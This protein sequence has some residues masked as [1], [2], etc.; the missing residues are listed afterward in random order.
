MIGCNRHVMHAVDAV[1]DTGAGPNLVHEAMLP[2]DW[3]RYT[4]T[5]LDF[6][7]IRDANN[8]SIRVEGAITLH[9]DIGGQ[10]L[11][12]HFLVCRELAV[13]VILGCSFIQRFVQAILPQDNKV[14]LRYGG[15]VAI[16]S[17]RTPDICVTHPSNKERSHP[18]PW[19]KKGSSRLNHV[20]VVTPIVIPP[21][22]EATIQVRC[23]RGGIRTILPSEDLMRK[24]KVSLTNGVVDALA[25]ACFLMKMANFSKR[26]VRLLKGTRVGTLASGPKFVVCPTLSKGSTSQDGTS[27]SSAA[28]WLKEVNLDHLDNN[29]RGKVEALLSK[30]HAVCDGR[31]GTLKGTIH[32]IETVPGA[33]PIFQQPYRCG[34]ERR[35]AEEA[36]VKRMLQ[37]GVIT[38]SNAEWASPVVFVPK[39]DGSLR[40]CVDYRKLNKITVRDSYPMPRMDEC[41]DSLG[42]AT[43]F[44]TLDCNSGYWQLPV[45][46]EDQDKTTFTCHA[47][48]YKFKRLPFG[49]R[50][51]PATFQRAMDIILSRVRWKYVLVYLDDIIIFSRGVQQH[52]SHLESVLRLLQAAGATL[53]LPKCHFFQRQV[54]YLGHIIRPGKLAIY[55]KNLEAI[56]KALPPRNKTQVRAFLGMCNVYRRFVNGF[57]RIAHP[58]NKKVCKDQP[59]SW[60]H[61]S[62]DELTAFEQLKKSLVTAPILALPREGY[63]YTLDTDASDRQLGC[64]LL[65]QQEDG[66]L[67]PIGYWSR[68]LTSAERNYSSTEKE[69]LAIVW[70]VQH[71][72]PYLEGTKFT[73]RTDHDALK[74]L[75]NLRDPRG[76]LARWSLRLQ[77]YDFDV[78]YRPGR[79]HAL[80][81]GP[82]RMLTAGLDESHFD[83]DI[84]CLP[85]FS[86]ALLKA[87]AT[88]SG[89]SEWPVPSTTVDTVCL[90]QRDELQ[91]PISIDEMLSEQAADEYCQWARRCMDQSQ[92]TSPFFIDQHGL[93][94][95]R[96]QLDGSLQLVV[97]LTLRKRLLTI[98]H[99][100]PSSGHPGRSK[101]YQT[102][103]RAF[104]W[105]SMTVDIHHIVEDCEPCARNR[106]KGQGNTYPMKLF[107]AT[108]PLEFVAMDIL[109]PL[110]RTRHGKRFILVITDRFTKLT[111]TVA[112]R[113]I[114]ALAVANAFCQTWVFNFGTPKVLLTDNGT[115]FTASFFRRVCQILG[116][117]KVFTTEYHP[118]ANGQAERFNRTIIAA[119]R[120]YVSDSQRDWDEWLGPLTYAYNTQVHRSTG[121]TPFDLVLSRHPPPLSVEVDML[122]HVPGERPRARRA[123]IAKAKEEFLLRLQ[124]AIVKARSNLLRTQQRYKRNFDAKVR[125]K[126]KDIQPGA[127]V[128]REIPEHPEG[129]NPK[130]ASPVDGPFEV[131]ENHWPTII[132]EVRGKPVRVNANRLTRAPTPRRNRRDNGYEQQPDASSSEEESV[133]QEDAA[134]NGS[135]T[136]Q[137]SHRAGPPAERVPPRQPG[138]PPNESPDIEE[139]ST[140]AQ[141]EPPEEV[142]PTSE[143]RP[144]TSSM[145][146]GNT[147]DVPGPRRGPRE[148]DAQPPR[149]KLDAPAGLPPASRRPP[150][151]PRKTP[152]SPRRQSRRLAA[153]EEQEYEVSKLIDAGLDEEGRE[154]YRVRWTG[155][156]PEEDTWEPASRLPRSLVR[157]YKQAR[158]L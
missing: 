3:R 44:T 99:N 133:L 145:P 130:L 77:E 138:S 140:A 5:G 122:D 26:E 79:T 43:V 95:R 81:D 65:Q 75:L 64:C 112:L 52:L 8:R 6:P 30:Y 37:A 94:V 12:T 16:Q 13:P 103:R 53:Q 14:V 144:S 29:V 139:R 118:Q 39:P 121:T 117:Q 72:R 20:R 24:H 63:P 76:R 91:S 125:S 119:I 25:G 111:K 123:R 124:E 69:C 137:R 36:E 96:A 134:P 27:P 156:G 23:D 88:G 84:P 155:Y 153:R 113:T 154:V 17:R 40:F 115:Q 127:F 80:A 129:V 47:G 50:N 7:C 143:G 131:L 2:K 90:L 152:H 68:T 100:A 18:C 71:L 45:A 35:K 104:Y 126:L 34:I 135:V 105:P 33:K 38:P 157:A 108:K 102:L 146:L 106:I 114:T 1:L 73:I 9:L 149:H 15:A 21:Y 151:S 61:L 56:T 10:T 107:P 101:M 142:P 158:G 67:H 28:D 120:N 41:I 92:G 22:S 58:L 31:L 85:R 60:E 78:V 98:A 59:E 132:I 49:L 136:P 87:S 51:A 110:P 11:R 42:S 19:K 70:A 32:R 66:T 147:P 4:Q 128:F 116:I 89:K 109:G 55:G 74:W 83:D 141:D 82:S 54:K 46:E 57:T 86:P 48:A 97:P 148:E 93:V 150:R 62:D